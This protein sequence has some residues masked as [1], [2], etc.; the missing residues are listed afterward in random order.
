[1]ALARVVTFDSLNPEN[2]ARIKEGVERGEVPE[3]MPPAEFLF[4][5]DEASNAGLVI[6]IVESEDDY[7]RAVEIMGGV[8][9]DEAPGPR[10]SVTKYRVAMRASAP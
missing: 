6:V 4:L 1:M 8:P 5:R 2:V 3:G 10:T 9:A 7:N